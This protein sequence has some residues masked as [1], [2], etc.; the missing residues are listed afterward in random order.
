M[1]RA[2]LMTLREGMDQGTATIRTQHLEWARS[3]ATG[4]RT[5]LPSLS[6]WDLEAVER[7]HAAY[8]QLVQSSRFQ[9]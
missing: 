8:E 9:D 2:E 7:A 6:P 1:S 3:L 4:N 5:E